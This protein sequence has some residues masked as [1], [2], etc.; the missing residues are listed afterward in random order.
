M[1]TGLGVRVSLRERL[2]ELSDKPDS[3]TNANTERQKHRTQTNG[4]VDVIS[5]GYENIYNEMSP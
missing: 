3:E 5:S 2:W 4:K 1:N